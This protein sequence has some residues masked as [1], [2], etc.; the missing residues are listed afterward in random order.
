M[1]YFS[2][3]ELSFLLHSKT[4]VTFGF[5]FVIVPVLSKMTVFILPHCSNASPERTRI[6]FFAPSPVPVIIAVGVARPKAQGQAITKTEVKIL[7]IKL[8]PLADIYRNH[9]EGMRYLVFG[10][11]ATVINLAVKFLFI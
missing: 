9:L 11:L 2:K 8:K 7:K 4:A 5:P 3:D 1:N 10:A 6:P